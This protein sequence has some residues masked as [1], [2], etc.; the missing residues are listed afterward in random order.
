MGRRA[1]AAPA[2]CPFVALL[3]AG[4]CQATQARTAGRHRPSPEC[5]IAGRHTRSTGDGVRHQTPGE[6]VRIRSGR[7]IACLAP[8]RAWT[9]R[10]WR[11]LR[12]R[13]RRHSVAVHSAD[14]A[15]VVRPAAGIKVNARRRSRTASSEV[16]PVRASASL[17]IRLR[18]RIQVKRTQPNHAC[19]RRSRSQDRSTDRATTLQNGDLRSVRADTD[20][21]RHAAEMARHHTPTSLRSP[22]PCRSKRAEPAPSN[23]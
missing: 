20:A 12:G 4:S 22:A 23:T 2:C 21:A 13:P 10:G 5:R 6:P 3:T 14:R 9:P 8:A 18:E 1:S 15:A 19:G 17:I 7:P 11:S 16:N